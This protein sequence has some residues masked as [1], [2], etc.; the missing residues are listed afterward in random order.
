MSTAKMTLIGMYN[1]DNT[2]FDFIELPAGIDKDILKNTILMHGGEFEVL[3]AQPDFMRFAIASWSKK[4]MRTFAEWLRGTEQTWN[5]IYNYDRFESIRDEHKKVYDA[6]TQADYTE[7]R[8]VDLDD[9]RTADLTDKTVLDNS[10]TTTQ[11]SD[12]QTEHQVSAYDSSDYQQSSKDIINIG[13]SR[14]DHNGTVTVT[15]SGND[16]MKHTG[17]EKTEKNGT[18]EDTAGSEKNSNI[19]EAHM[20]GNIGVSTSSSMLSEFY[21]I[22]AWNLYEHISDIFISELL[23]PVY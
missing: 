7:K 10:D 19:H 8:T 16:I 5:P 12:G 15:N 22:S 21:R 6:K 1:Y 17:T 23:I 4:W 9:T 11:I 18:T 13:E 20:Y 2:L 14:V 3:Y